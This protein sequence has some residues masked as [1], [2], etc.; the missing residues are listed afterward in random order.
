MAPAPSDEDG[1]YPSE[2]GVP[3]DWKSGDVYLDLYEVKALLGQGGMVK[4][5]KVHHRRWGIDLAVK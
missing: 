2:D 1:E 3:V 4:V 5:F